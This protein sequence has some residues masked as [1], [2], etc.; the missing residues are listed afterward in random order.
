M[1]LVESLEGI[2][3]I[4]LF[5]QSEEQREKT[6]EDMSRIGLS[7]AQEKQLEKE[8]T[9]RWE[10]MLIPPQDQVKVTVQFAASSS[11]S[12]ELILRKGFE[13]EDFHFLVDS[14]LKDQEWEA[15]GGEQRWDANEIHIFQNG[16]ITVFPPDWR[17]C[18]KR[19][20]QKMR[21]EEAWD[22]IKG[23]LSNLPWGW[24]TWSSD[25]SQEATAMLKFPGE[26]REYFVRLPVGSEWAYIKSYANKRLDEGTWIASLVEERWCDHFRKPKQGEIIRFHWIEEKPLVYP[27]STKPT[28]RKIEEVQAISRTDEPTDLPPTNW[29]GNLKAPLEKIQIRTQR[30]L[31]NGEES[32]LTPKHIIVQL[33]VP[34]IEILRP[35]LEKPPTFDSIFMY[36]L[37]AVRWKS[38]FQPDIWGEKLKKWRHIAISVLDTRAPSWKMLPAWKRLKMKY[39]PFLLDDSWDNAFEQAYRRKQTWEWDSLNLRTMRAKNK[40]VNLQLALLSFY[41]EEITDEAHSRRMKTLPPRV[42]QRG[43]AIFLGET[44]DKIDSDT[45]EI[46]EEDLEGVDQRF[47]DALVALKDVPIRH[48]RLQRER[49]W[50]WLEK[51]KLSWKK[52]MSD[53]QKRWSSQRFFERFV[54]AWQRKAA[55]WQK[56]FDKAKEDLRVFYKALRKRNFTYLSLPGPKSLEAM[57]ASQ[58]ETEAERISLE[59][60]VKTAQWDWEE[61]RSKLNNHEDKEKLIR[62]Q[63]ADLTTQKV[64]V[65]TE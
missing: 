19:G 34:P 23:T 61:A 22:R 1:T 16:V 20:I 15:W 25:N 42:V 13:W 58:E 41:N 59:N 55:M 65:G 54:G 44:P 12:E 9:P 50:E 11:Y 37:K 38:D 32:L 45:W 60:A 8:R 3:G 6:W 36:D 64:Q 28:I 18:D 62:A 56:E 17:T 27:S 26:I 52:D 7:N 2:N 4:F 47:S 49:T 46:K 48:L 14:R 43:R 39:G 5:N 10:H 21:E 51:E 40:E 33:A 63:K 24:E 31:P 35:M 29:T 30:P 53:L 57:K